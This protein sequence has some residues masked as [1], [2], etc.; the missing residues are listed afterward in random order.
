MTTALFITAPCHH[1]TLSFK[2]QNLLL[3]QTFS[4]VDCWLPTELTDF[5]VTLDLEI[6]RPPV[7]V[8]RED[9]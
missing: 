7:T 5:I 2:L 6:I 8:V 9:L 3:P 1:V 4:T